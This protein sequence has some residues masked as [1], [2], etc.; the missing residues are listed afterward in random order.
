[1]RSDSQRT[2][3]GDGD[4]AVRHPVEPRAR[5]A[6]LPP[7]MVCFTLFVLTTA[8]KL[9]SKVVGEDPICWLGFQEESIMTSSLEGM[10]YIIYPHRLCRSATDL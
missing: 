9:Q 8:N 3:D 1:M 2:E 5:T 4:G 7:I 6:L 10:F